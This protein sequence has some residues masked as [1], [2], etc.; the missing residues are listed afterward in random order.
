MLPLFSCLQ[1]SIQGRVKEL[2]ESAASDDVEGMKK[3]IEALQQEVMKMG[4]AMYGQPGVLA[5]GAH[6]CIS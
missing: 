2:R 1:A 5:G 6:V 4:Q 3:G